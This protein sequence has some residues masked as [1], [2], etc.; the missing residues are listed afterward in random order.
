[1]DSAKKFA[2][3]RI[4]FGAVWAVDVFSKWQPYFFANFT[5]YLTNGAEGQ[6]LL[7]QRWI[8]LWINI[9]GIN[10]HLFALF[11]AITETAIALGLIM[12]IFTP[13]VCY[14]G[15][16]FSSVIWSTAEGFGGPYTVGS[17]DIGTAI[18]YA[19]VFAALLIGQCWKVW[20]IDALRK[21]Y[22]L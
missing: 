19:L 12:G 14:G 11:V 3:L 13:L 1:M 6:P 22:A 18:I 10:P 5:S 20:S 16:L 7:V 8:N 21:K 17:T 9:V 15:I 4:I 2:I